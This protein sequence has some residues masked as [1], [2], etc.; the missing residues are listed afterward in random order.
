MSFVIVTVDRI[1]FQRPPPKFSLPLSLAAARPVIQLNDGP[2]I[3]VGYCGSSQPSEGPMADSHGVQIATFQWFH[4]S[5]K[6]G[7]FAGD[8]ALTFV[9]RD[10][11]V[12]GLYHRE[13]Q[14]LYIEALDKDISINF[15]KETTAEDR[16]RRLAVM[17]NDYGQG[18]SGD[19]RQEKFPVPIKRRKGRTFGFTPIMENIGGEMK[20]NIT[21]PGVKNAAKTQLII[22][23]HPRP[24]FEPE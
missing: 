24:G 9:N 23:I 22:K 17:Y 3:R 21:A 14:F 4:S 1:A 13:R 16:L 11:A 20:M 8:E 6:G 12:L 2:A 5:S 10:I 18:D 15:S 7:N 19:Y